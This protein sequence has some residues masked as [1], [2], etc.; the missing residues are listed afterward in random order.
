MVKQV[1]KALLDLGRCERGDT[2]VIIAGSPTGR[3]GSTNAMRVHRIGD[4]VTGVAPT[5]TP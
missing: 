3:T 2:I 4:I 1:D 5:T